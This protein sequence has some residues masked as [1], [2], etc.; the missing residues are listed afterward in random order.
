MTVRDFKA[1]ISRKPTGAPKKPVKTAPK[2][3]V[4]TAKI[5]GLKKKQQER[6]MQETKNT[7]KVSF[8]HWYR[9]TLGQSC[10]PSSVKYS[11]ER[12]RWH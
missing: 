3:L 9:F 11:L 1:S 4:K 6:T 12:A 10:S 2:K 7:R 8:L 5:D